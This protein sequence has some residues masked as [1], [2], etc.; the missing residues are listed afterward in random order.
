MSGY[1]MCR[2]PWARCAPWPEW[3]IDRA[4]NCHELG[5]CHGLGDCHE[6]AHG[7]AE[8]HGLRIVRIQSDN[9]LVFTGERGAVLHSTNFRRR[10]CLPA[11]R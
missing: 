10:I 8:A 1:I 6:A 11:G 9:G 4:R 7:I 5:H 2:V 3:S